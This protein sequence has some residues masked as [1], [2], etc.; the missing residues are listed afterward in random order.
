MRRCAK[1]LGCV[2]LGA[3][4]AGCSTVPPLTRGQADLLAVGD[5]A[6][7]VAGKLGKSTP[8]HSHQFGARDGRYRADHFNLQVGSQQTGTVICTPT[9]TYV[10]IWVPVFA[11]YVVLYTLPAERVAAFGTL[12]ELSKSPNEAISG[13]MPDLKASYEKSLAEKKAAK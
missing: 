4:L 6:P 1:L 10:P 5:T 8:L 9:C 13:V 12:E 11:S 7:Q 2:L 3:V